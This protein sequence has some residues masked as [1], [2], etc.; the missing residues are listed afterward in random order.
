ML[1][2]TKK[3]T[4]QNKKENIVRGHCVVVILLLDQANDARM[5]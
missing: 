3:H 2:H 4:E 1:L 5:R